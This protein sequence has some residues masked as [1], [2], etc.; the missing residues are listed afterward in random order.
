MYKILIADDEKWIRAGLIQTVDWESYGFD[1]ILEAA[2]GR[3]ALELAL[4]EKP[5]AMIADIKMPRM[6]G[7][8]LTEQLRQSGSDIYVMLI[9]GFSDFVYAQ[10]AIQCGV[11]EYILKPVESEKLDSALRKCRAFLDEVRSRNV[12]NEHRQKYTQYLTIAQ[13]HYLR[14]FIKGDDM[15]NSPSLQTAMTELGLDCSDSSALLAVLRFSQAQTDVGKITAE[16]ESFSPAAMR[17]IF[18]G[19]STNELCVLFLDPDRELLLS[20]ASSLIKMMNERDHDLVC[21]YGSIVAPN[22]L[23]ESYDSAVRYCDFRFFRPDRKLGP[24]KKNLPGTRIVL[25]SYSQLLNFILSSNFNAARAH[26]RNCFSQLPAQANQDNSPELRK[27]LLNKLDRVFSECLARGIFREDDCTAVLLK[28][29]PGQ[30]SIDR[31]EALLDEVF[32]SME[33]NGD[34]Q[35]GTN[36]LSQA[37]IAYVKEHFRENI[38]MTTVANYL[39]VNSSYFS[40]VFSEQVGIPFTK[41]LN[42]HRVSVAKQ[43]LTDPAIK[44]YEVAHLVGFDDYRYFSKIFKEQ[45]G[46]P[47]DQY[48]NLLTDD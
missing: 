17:C 42:S 38:S 32:S 3:S 44:I 20:S 33:G 15:P 2:D 41:Y 6:T 35:A 30:L 45:E 9:S 31:T 4:K 40:H 27:K 28:E 48:R 1:R 24:E 37:A 26:I 8:E 18:P 43:L 19:R 23:R 34:S 5:D 25:P 39:C 16:I 29:L 10:K 13:R 47:P 22:Q 36:Q 46:I 14:D 12:E 11:K 21:S 7:I